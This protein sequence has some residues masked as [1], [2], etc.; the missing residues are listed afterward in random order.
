MEHKDALFI[1]IGITLTLI[2]VAVSLYFRS[3][4]F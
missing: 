1:G 3:G 4:L 2:V